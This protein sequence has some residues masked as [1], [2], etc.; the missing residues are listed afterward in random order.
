VPQE[1]SRPII[2]QGTIITGQGCTFIDNGTERY[3][4]DGNLP[5][6][7]ELQVTGILSGNRITAESTQPVDLTPETLL[8]QLRGFIEELKK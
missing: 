1:E 2:F 4:I 3:L 5:H 7:S 8:V 6:G